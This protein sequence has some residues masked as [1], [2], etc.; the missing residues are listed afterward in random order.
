MKLEAMKSPMTIVQSREQPGSPDSQPP[1][2]E[3]PKGTSW[4]G[5]VSLIL[6]A[7]AICLIGIGFL[8][9]LI[10]ARSLDTLLAVFGLIC[11]GSVLTLPGMAL[12][13]ASL[14]RKGRSNAAGVAG[15]W[16]NGLILGAWLLLFALGWPPRQ[17]NPTV[18]PY[19]ASDYFR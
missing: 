9:V 1:V 14:A 19:H 18:A 10:S 13:V 8:L 17:N 12:G 4:L 6:G 5:G 2:F 16:I 3:P 11:F 15:C 7:A